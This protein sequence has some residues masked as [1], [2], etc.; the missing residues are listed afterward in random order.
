MFA[1]LHGKK[2][3]D[4][5]DACRR[6][7]LLTSQLKARCKYAN[8]K[9]EKVSAWSVGQHIEHVLA[10]NAHAVL[11]LSRDAENE[12]QISPASLETLAMLESGTIPRGAATAPEAVQPK[13][14]NFVDLTA[15]V[16]RNANLLESTIVIH[17]QIASDCSLYA[18][19]V[20][21]GLTKMQWLRYLEIHILHHMK[22]I[23]DIV[24]HN[25]P[26]DGLRKGAKV[27][28]K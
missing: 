20:L 27:Q 6:V 8:A 16:E 18:H 12:K 28:R 9:F 22:I 3:I 4:A 1:D 24:G 25:A 2:S 11:I 7:F 26:A 10:V 5:Y 14:N 13:M 15:D 19:P 17:N 21:G 23:A